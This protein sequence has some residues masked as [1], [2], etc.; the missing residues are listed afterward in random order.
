MRILFFVL[1]LLLAACASKP[2]LLKTGQLYL[3]IAPD[4][5]GNSAFRLDVI[6]TSDPALAA[7]ILAL[8]PA[9][10]FAQRQQMAALHASTLKV[11]GAELVPGQAFGPV[12]LTAKFR[13]TSGLVAI[14]Y[15]GAAAGFAVLG[16]SAAELLTLNRTGFALSAA[17]AGK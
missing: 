15:D 16:A 9:A 10:W 13:I 7:E 12:A 4:A 14:G 6:L 1:T 3:A 5:N 8:T 17:G 11:V 2:P